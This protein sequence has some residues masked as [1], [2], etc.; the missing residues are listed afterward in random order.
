[1]LKNKDFCPGCHEPVEGATGYVFEEAPIVL[2]WPS[3]L[4]R[5]HSA[6]YGAAQESAI[7]MRKK[8]AVAT[9]ANDKK[10]AIV[11]QRMRRRQAITRGEAV[12]ATRNF[13]TSKTCDALRGVVLMLILWAVIVGVASAAPQHP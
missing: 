13:I 12:Q 6:C 11:S 7:R 1:M 9:I 3:G 5:W 8:Q 10:R 2:G 4:F